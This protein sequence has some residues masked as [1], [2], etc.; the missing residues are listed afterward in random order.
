MEQI[1][2]QNDNVTRLPSS[3]LIDQIKEERE[4]LVDRIVQSQKAIEQSRE[5][6]ARIDRMLVAVEKK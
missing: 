5:L 4:R 1:M 6:I 3:E 2:G